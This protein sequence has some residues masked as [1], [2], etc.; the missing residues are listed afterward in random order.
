MQ[1]LPLLTAIVLAGG[2]G[3]MVM[4]LRRA[5]A[6]RLSLFL[7]GC[8]TTQLGLAMLANA[9]LAPGFLQ[10]TTAVAFTVGAILTLG[11]EVRRDLSGKGTTR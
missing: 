1:Y 5:P 2:V 11:L 7:A 8:T 6:R 10:T 9:V 4:A 3:L